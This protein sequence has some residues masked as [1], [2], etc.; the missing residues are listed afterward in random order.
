MRPTA[1]TMRVHQPGGPL[2]ADRLAVEKPAQG[3]VRVQVTASG[4]CHADIG[5]SAATGGATLP[6]TPGHEVAGVIA[7]LGAGIEG[8]QIGERVA[9]GWFG[10]SCGRCERCRR[11]DVVH[12][13]DRMIPGVSYPGGWAESITVPAD[14]LA[15]I[16]DDL[17]LYEAAPMGCAGVTTFNAV[18]HCGVPAGG[19]IA[20]F[21]VGGLGHLA[22]QFAA[23]MGHEVTAIARGASREE[24]ARDLGARHYLDSTAGDAGSLL[25]DTGGADV[26]ISTTSTTAPL[27]ELIRGLRPRGQL[28]VIGVD[29]GS[30]P[31]PAGQL[32]ANAQSVTGHITGSSLDIEETLKFAQLNDIRPK[33]ERAPLEDAGRQLRRLANGEPRFRIVLD[34]SP[35]RNKDQ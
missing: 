23:K 22:I 30:I 6:I 32:V 10:G 27:D 26:I 20:V 34:A 29:G 2:D 5:T 3:W 19:R 28:I 9:V 7:E 14:A 4:M 17:D 21:G 16:P 24:L 13:P 31:I 25:R 12:C 15:R 33:I 1:L 8:W 11:G 18:R 35:E